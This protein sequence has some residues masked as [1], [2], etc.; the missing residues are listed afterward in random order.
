M[1]KIAARNMFYDEHGKH[2]RTKKEILNENGQIRRGCKVIPKGG[3]MSAV[4]L[5]AKIAY[6]KARD[7]LMK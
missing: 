5:Q 1:E 4:F 7:F 2:V 6:L 3:Y